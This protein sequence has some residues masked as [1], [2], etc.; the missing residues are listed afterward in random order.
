VSKVLF[1]G[2]VGRAVQVQKVLQ[3][4]VQQLLS[5]AGATRCAVQVEKVLQV[6]QV[7]V[8]QLLS[9]A[10]AAECCCCSGLGES[11]CPCCHV[12]QRVVAVQALERAAVHAVRCCRVLLLSKCCPAAAGAVQV[13]VHAVQQVGIRC[14]G[15]AIGRDLLLERSVELLS[16]RCCP[17][18]GEVQ[19]PPFGSVLKQFLDSPPCGPAWAS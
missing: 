4:T 17:R 6:V 10:G 11:C 14:Y 8:Q 2:V 12:L 5:L 3:V 1:R 7:A 18:L 16:S 9:L 13:A 15:S 19:N